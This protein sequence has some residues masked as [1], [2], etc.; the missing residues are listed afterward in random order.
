MKK[1][2]ILLLVFVSSHTIFAQNLPS[3]EE[4][5][6]LPVPDFLTITLDIKI[7]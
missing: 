1:L 7:L 5:D 3:A 2:F 6:V 4:W